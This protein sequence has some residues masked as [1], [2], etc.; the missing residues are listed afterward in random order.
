MPARGIDRRRLLK[1][2]GA[3][4]ALMVSPVGHAA[5]ASLL[6]VRVW[7]SAEY[8]RITLEGSST[9]R[10]SH[11]LVPDP[12]RLVVDLEGIHL[13]SVLQS[14]PSKVISPTPTSA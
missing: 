14:L 12:D 5:P 9:L 11:M 7:P 4:L 13:D 6:A 10:Y 2:A 8:T 3:T 1:F